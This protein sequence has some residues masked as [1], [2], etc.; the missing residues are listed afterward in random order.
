[1]PMQCALIKKAL[2]ENGGYGSPAKSCKAP[3][4]DDPDLW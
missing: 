1:M 3:T 2:T 4:M